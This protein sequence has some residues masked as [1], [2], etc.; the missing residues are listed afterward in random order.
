[1]NHC[2]TCKHWAAPEAD[3]RRVPITGECKA[4]PHYWDVSEWSADGR[5][6]VIK[7][8]YAHCLAFS[9]DGSDYSASLETLPDFGCVQHQPK[10]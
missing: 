10:E 7:K 8:E 9:Q 2:K 3:S 4:V 1:M 6:R 5:S